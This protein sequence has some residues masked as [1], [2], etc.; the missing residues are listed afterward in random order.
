MGYNLDL[1]IGLLNLN[2]TKTVRSCACKNGSCADCRGD[3]A[4][5]AVKG[6]QGVHTELLTTVSIMVNRTRNPVM[7]VAKEWS[8][9]STIGSGYV[10]SVSYLALNPV[11]SHTAKIFDVVSRGDLQQLRQMLRDG[12]ASLRDTDEQGWSLLFVSSKFCIMTQG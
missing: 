1:P 8:A 5:G 6:R 7:I 9:T 3:T 10:A 2:Q 12:E 11:I 4:M